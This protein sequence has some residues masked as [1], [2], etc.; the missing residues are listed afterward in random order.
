MLSRIESRKTDIKKLLNPCSLRSSIRCTRIRDKPGWPPFALPDED[1]PF[2]GLVPEFIPIRQ[3][4]SSNSGTA[5][6]ERHALVDPQEVPYPFQRLNV[7]Q[8]RQAIDG[9][10][11]AAGDTIDG[12][13]VFNEMLK[14]VELLGGVVGGEVLRGVF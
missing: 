2:L 11:L 4:I 3:N 8:K 9:W 6:G 12:G 10:F 7:G 14:H 1:A 13:A 5:V